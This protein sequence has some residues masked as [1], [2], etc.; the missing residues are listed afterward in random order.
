MDISRDI[1]QV[2][3][4]F[5][6][7]LGQPKA[8][9]REIRLLIAGSCVDYYDLLGDDVLEGQDQ[10]FTVSQK[11][12]WLNLG[13]WREAQT[14]PDACVAM[15]RLVAD[16]A[17]FNKNDVVLDAGFGFGEQDLFW[18]DNYQLQRI[19]GI[20]ITPSHVSKARERVE[21]LGLNDTIDL[22]LGSAISLDLDTSSVDKVVALE[23]AFHF[24]TRVAFLQEAFRVLK[25]GG[26]IVLADVVPSIGEKSH[27]LSQ[28]IGLRRWGVP[29]AN[30]YDSEVYCEKLREL[31][32][33]RIAAKTISDDVFPGIAQYAEQRRLGRKMEEIRVDPTSGE[34]DS[35]EGTEEWGNRF[36]SLDYVIFSAEKPEDRID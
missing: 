32:Y 36:G 16:T 30:L 22:R 10:K 33:V 12:L 18:V 9:W 26:R 1:G 35:S 19:V 15:A 21:Q 6:N 14:Y 8:L 20:N 29:R 3:F 7:L 4:T 13:Y 11:P 17:A 5:I 31:G 34:F 24:D 27:S 23:S 2:S 28:W 25:P